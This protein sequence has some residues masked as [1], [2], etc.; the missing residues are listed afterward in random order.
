MAGQIEQRLGMGRGQNG[1]PRPPPAPRP[2]CHVDRTAS[3]DVADPRRVA[4]QRQN[5][6]HHVLFCFIRIDTG[7]LLCPRS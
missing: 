5:P 2:D 7:L 6:G 1:N 3:I 4:M